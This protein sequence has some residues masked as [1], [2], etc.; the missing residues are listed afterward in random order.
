MLKLKKKKTNWQVNWRTCTVD[1]GRSNATIIIIVAENLIQKLLF[2]FTEI[3]F[4]SVSL[5]IPP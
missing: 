3:R 5:I 2:S 4:A 1:S